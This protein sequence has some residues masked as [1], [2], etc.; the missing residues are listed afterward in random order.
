M[1]PFDMPHE[2]FEIDGDHLQNHRITRETFAANTHA[3]D[4]RHRSPAR[5]RS[6]GGHV[7]PSGDLCAL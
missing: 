4:Q 5:R 3:V 6:R 2:L 1:T 7:R